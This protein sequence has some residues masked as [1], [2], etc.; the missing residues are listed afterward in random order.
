MSWAGILWSA[1]ASIS[2]DIAKWLI[3]NAFLF[4]ACSWWTVPFHNRS[5]S[6]SCV[7]GIVVGDC[8]STFPQGLAHRIDERTSGVRIVDCREGGGAGSRCAST[9]GGGR[10]RFTSFSCP[11]EGRARSKWRSETRQRTCSVR[12]FSVQWVAFRKVRL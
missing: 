4:F 5:S 9:A 10:P 7:F 8:F 1:S 3:R 2:E 6:T 12:F 11:S